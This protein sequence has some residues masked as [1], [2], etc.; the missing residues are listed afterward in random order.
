V[1]LCFVIFTLGYGLG[2]KGARADLVFYPKSDCN[3]WTCENIQNKDGTWSGYTGYA[4]KDGTVVT[5]CRVKSGLPKIKVCRPSM[6][7]C[8][9]PDTTVKVK[10]DGEYVISPTGGKADCYVQWE[11][12]EIPKGGG[13]N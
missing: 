9:V 5:D 13:E 3:E 7:L 12:C 4:T 11:K 10:C 2:Q 6:A 8:E 1:V